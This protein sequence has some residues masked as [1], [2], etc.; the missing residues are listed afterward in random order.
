MCRGILICRIPVITAIDLLVV[1]YIS[2]PDCFDLLFIPVII[3]LAF[4]IAIWLTLI[5]KDKDI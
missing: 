1:I 5:I 2:V 4:I 3:F